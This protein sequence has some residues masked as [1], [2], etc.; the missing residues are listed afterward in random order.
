MRIIHQGILKVEAE[1]LGNDRLPGYVHEDE[2]KKIE[3]RIR[4]RFALL[5]HLYEETEGDTFKM[6]LHAD[7]ANELGLDH[8]FVISQ[9]LPYMAKEGWIIG[10]TADSITITEAGI[11][12]VK[13][14]LTK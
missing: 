2:I 8:H 4:L 13:A 6:V 3:Q 1:L 11:D 7:L 5:R 12:R 14:L 10:H 9:L